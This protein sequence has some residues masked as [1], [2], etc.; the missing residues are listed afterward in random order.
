MSQ[1]VCGLILTKLRYTY[2]IAGNGREALEA[3]ECATFAGILPDC[4]MPEMDGF[5]AAR[6]IRAREGAGRDT[7]PL[8]IPITALTAGATAG[9]R[10]RC[11][12]DGM[13]DYVSKPVRVEVLAA[14]LEAWAPVSPAAIDGNLNYAGIRSRYQSTEQ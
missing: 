10:E 11:L 9:E 2:E 7:V 3:L 1:K 8:H 5:E 14:R 12:A 13:D 4:Q 6:A